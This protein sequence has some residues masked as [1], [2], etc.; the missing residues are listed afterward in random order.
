MKENE[1]SAGQALP[2][3]F[4]VE[5][6]AKN[7]YSKLLQ[8]VK[9]ANVIYDNASTP[10]EVSQANEMLSQAIKSMDAFTGELSSFE[11]LD[12]QAIE[13][14][15]IAEPKLTQQLKHLID[16]AGQQLTFAKDKSKTLLDYIKAFND[17]INA[18]TEA[19][20]RLNSTTAEGSEKAYNALSSLTDA[21]QALQAKVEKQGKASE[22]AHER[23]YNEIQHLEDFI[24]GGCYVGIAAFA[25]IYGYPLLKMIWRLLC[26]LYQAL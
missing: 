4:A 13:K 11:Q 17:T 8:V 5:Q 6:A 7:N 16:I 26:M 15:G 3:A 9:Q 19:L 2:S 1:G 25:L 20:N 23:L 18:N 12:K 24:V 22:E 10:E 21:I 14:V